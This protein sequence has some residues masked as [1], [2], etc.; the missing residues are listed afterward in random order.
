MVHPHSQHKLEGELRWKHAHKHQI[1]TF[2]HF[3][4]PK[5]IVQTHRQ[6]HTWLHLFI[7]NVLQSMYR[8]AFLV[9]FHISFFFCFVLLSSFISLRSIRCF[10]SQFEIDVSAYGMYCMWLS[11]SVGI[12]FPFF[13]SFCCGCVCPSPSHTASLV[14]MPKLNT[15][16]GSCCRYYVYYYIIIV[17]IIFLYCYYVHTPSTAI[18]GGRNRKHT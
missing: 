2:S 5:N 13:I 18:F 16:G 4:P 7:R 15:V 8:N 12:C 10:H 6:H 14:E 11:F 3:S 17:I 9:V 1:N